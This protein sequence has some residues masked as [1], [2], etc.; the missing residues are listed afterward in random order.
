MTNLPFRSNFMMRVFVYPSLTKKLPS[1]R[2]AMSVGRPK[3]LS[4]VPATSRSPRVI[5]SCVPS[6]VNLKICWA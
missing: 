3:C 6:L 2:N 5:T 4:S 1:G